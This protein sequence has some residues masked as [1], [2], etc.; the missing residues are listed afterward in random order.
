MSEP[1]KL[2][3]S[4]V[5][6]WQACVVAGLR[7]GEEQTI[8]QVEDNPFRLWSVATADAAVMALRERTAN[9]EHGELY[10]TQCPSCC[11]RFTSSAPML[12]NKCP[13]CGHE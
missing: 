3:A 12:L 9:R 2:D 6:F 11:N 4:E 13:V 7:S 10:S 1:I 8:Y 5:E